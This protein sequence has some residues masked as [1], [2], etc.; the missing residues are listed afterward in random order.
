MT[1]SQSQLM[2]R[3]GSNS[4]VHGMKKHTERMKD[5]NIRN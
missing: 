2:H 5:A 4:H 3:Q 1:G